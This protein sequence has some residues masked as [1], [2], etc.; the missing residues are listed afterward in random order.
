MA[1]AVQQSYRLDDTQFD[2]LAFG[3]DAQSIFQ[4][5]VTGGTGQAGGSGGTSN[6]PAIEQV[7]RRSEIRYTYMDRRER[8]KVDHAALG[9]E[10]E[11]A[12]RRVWEVCEKDREQVGMEEGEN[13]FPDPRQVREGLEALD[14]FAGDREEER[15][16]VQH[17]V[18]R[19]AAAVGMRL[20]SR[21]L[22][23]TGDGRL[24]M[25]HESV[26][27][28]DEV[29]E[30]DGLMAPAVLKKIEPGAF[31]F[32]GEAFVLGLMPGEGRARTD[33][34]ELVDVVLK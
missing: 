18:D 10:V 31:R 32:V 13:G 25:G 29:W 5:E 7:L 26:C 8:D 3:K 21:R 14:H 19:F 23:Y 20:D 28:G 12:L 24:G 9:R 34:S 16:E 6:N 11:E 15:R 30:I 17:R 33:V 27:D 4:P 2:A 1:E 22:F